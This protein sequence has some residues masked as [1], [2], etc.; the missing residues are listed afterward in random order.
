MEDRCH[1]STLS[2]RSVPVGPVLEAVTE[3]AKYIV[4]RSAVGQAEER[5]HINGK[6]RS[7]LINQTSV[8]CSDPGARPDRVVEFNIATQIP[9]DC[10][11]E[12]D[13]ILPLHTHV[14]AARLIENVDP[15]LRKQCETP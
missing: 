12:P 10:A 5:I 15:G 4:I 7:D 3:T 11:G 8:E 14:A 1:E 9:D 13:R 2:A 6:I